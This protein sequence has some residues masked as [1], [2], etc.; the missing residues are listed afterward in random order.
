M[1]RA[2]LRRRVVGGGAHRETRRGETVAQCLAS[3]STV[4]L[5]D[6]YPVAFLDRYLKDAPAGP[7]LHSRAEGLDDYRFAD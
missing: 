7:A 2:L 5:I 3:T 6:D 1:A 4:R